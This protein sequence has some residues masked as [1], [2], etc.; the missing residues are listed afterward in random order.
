MARSNRPPKKIT[1][2]RWKGVKA[3][4]LGLSAGS[5]ASVAL[6]AE[7]FPD[8]VM[9]TRGELVGT[10][11]GVQPGTGILTRWSFGLVCVPEGTSSTVIWSP[12]AD[13]NA[14]WF[15]YATGHLGY[16][17]YV[18]DVVQGGAMSSFRMDIDSRAMRKCPPDMEL[19]A[20]FEQE[21]IAGA[22][23]VNLAFAGRILLGR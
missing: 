16:D 19:Q 12:I 13:A 2:L 6:A 21:T 9:R 3:S 11:D 14:P 23:P 8:T 7:S 22:S 4:A 5:V 1:T 15:V 17:E 10:L 18:D 20:V